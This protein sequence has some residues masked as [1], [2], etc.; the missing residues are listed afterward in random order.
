[1][2]TVAAVAATEHSLLK[3]KM[4]ENMDDDAQELRS[5]REKG[6]DDGEDDDASEALVGPEPLGRPP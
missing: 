6:D 5:E 4:D 3:S 1:M 2:A